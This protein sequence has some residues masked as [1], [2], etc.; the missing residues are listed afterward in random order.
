MRVL[1]SSFFVFRGI[2]WSQ[3][4]LRAVIGVKGEKKGRKSRL[5][6]IL[7]RKGY[8]N[9]TQRIVAFPFEG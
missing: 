3:S 6:S 7:D 4:D 1:F 2:G 8:V 9:V 5:R